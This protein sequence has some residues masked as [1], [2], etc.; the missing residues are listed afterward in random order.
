VEKK[1]SDNLV[2]VTKLMASK[3][4]CSRREAEVWIADGRVIVNDE[5][6]VE[7]GTKVD[8]KVDDITVDGD[9]LPKD[10][11]HIYL[12]LNKPIGYLSSFKKG[13]EKG[14]T[15]DKIIK[16][17]RRLFTVGRLDRD[18]CGLLF[19]TTDGDWADKVA[20]PKHQKEKEYLIRVKKMRP[21]PAA[22]RLAK[23]SFREQNKIFKAKSVS[24]DGSYIN[25]IL[26]EGRNRQIRKLA[27]SVELEVK[28]LIRIR[29][30][31]IYLEDL[32]PGKYR[33]LKDNEIKSFL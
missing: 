22:K 9:R 21:T 14:E 25:I 15:L 4:L 2:R 13:E 11:K 33:K 3:G 1:S 29:V 12:A 31:T 26:E 17:Q 16:I 28:E 20:H 19:L 10:Q 5:I 27:E 23:A 24:P 8:P 6:I 32:K 18:S 7:P 30:G